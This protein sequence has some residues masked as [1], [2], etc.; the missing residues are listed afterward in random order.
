MFN[1]GLFKLGL[2]A[3]AIHPLFLLQ[4]FRIHTDKAVEPTIFISSSPWLSYNSSSSS[5]GIGR[6]PSRLG[7]TNI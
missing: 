3:R 6:R 1:V 2:D 7:T 4:P 5:S